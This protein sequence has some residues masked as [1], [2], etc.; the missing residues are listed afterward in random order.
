MTENGLKELPVT[1][2]RRRPW[3]RS[4]VLGVVILLCGGAIGSVVTAV[5]LEQQPMHGMRR[6]DRL[7]Q[8]IAEEMQ[9]KYNLTDDQEQKILAIFEEHTNKLS[10]IRREVQPRVDAEH[11]AVRRSVEAVLTAEQAEQWR[12]EYEQMRRLWHPRPAESSP[13][14]QQ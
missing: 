11:E 9:R 5:V 10:A 12:K 4:L 14:A 3:V 6:P 7:P 8:R 2:A 13:P 1:P